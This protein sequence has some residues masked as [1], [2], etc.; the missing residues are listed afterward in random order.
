MLRNL[1][2][3][4][5]QVRHLTADRSQHNNTT[6]QY[7]I[8]ISNIGDNFFYKMCITPIPSAARLSGFLHTPYK[9]MFRQKIYKKQQKIC[10]KNIKIHG[11][12]N[13]KSTGKSVEVSISIYQKMAFLQK[14]C[15]RTVTICHKFT[16]N[17]HS[18]VSLYTESDISLKE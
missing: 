11:K 12:N 16:K 3:I 17:R 18:V 8:S 10:G 14:S 6:R 2:Q 5:G 7:R 1:G 15:L 9:Q 4:C 13:K